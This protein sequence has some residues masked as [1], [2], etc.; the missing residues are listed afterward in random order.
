MN[1][2]PVDPT[3]FG[4]VLRD[5]LGVRKDDKGGRVKYINMGLRP[6]ALRVVA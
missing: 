1:L 4:I 2:T 5:E 6:A 3:T